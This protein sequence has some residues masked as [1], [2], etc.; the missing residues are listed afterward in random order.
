MGDDILRRRHA[1]FAAEEM[2]L[3][4]QIPQAFRGSKKIPFGPAMP[5]ET[6]MNEC[7]PHDNPC[8]PL[9]RVVLYPR[10]HV[11]PRNNS[12]AV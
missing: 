8:W 5:I 1:I 2:N 3:M 7:D 12:S 9:I 6:F 10:V 11:K 4:P